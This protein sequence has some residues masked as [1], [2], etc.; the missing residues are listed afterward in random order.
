MADTT[1]TNLALTKPE[2]GASTDT[3]GTKINTDLDTLDAVFKGDGTGTSTGLNV[4]SG[5]TLAVAGTATFTGTATA[6]TQSSGDN[7]TKLATTAY[8]SAITGTSGITGFK[9]RIINPQMQF[10]QRNAGSAVTAGSGYTLDRWNVDRLWTGSTVTIQQS[11]TAPSGFTNSLLAT[12]STGASVA[13]GSYFSIQQF[14]EGYNTADFALGTAS[15]SQFTLSFWVRSSVTGT[16]GVGF[17]NSAF[18]LS[19]WTTYTISAANTWEQKSVTIAAP[20]SGTFGTGNSYGLNTIFSLGCGSTNKAAS[21]NS[22]NAGGKLGA[23][24]QTDLIATTGATFYVTGVQ[25]EKGT[26]ATSFDY[27]P[28]GTELALCQRYFFKITGT[29]RHAIGGNGSIASS[30]P[31]VFLPVTM[32]TTPSLGYSALSDFNSEAIAGAGQAVATAISINTYTT[33]SITLQLT[34]G[35]SSTATG[36][37]L[38]GNGGGASSWT[39]YSAEL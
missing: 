35:G 24:G 27:R 26:Q 14:M 10:D 8:V 5:K 37:Q 25:L 13:A 39:S 19:Y 38:L 33:Q 9:N 31:T 28:Y 7:S 17:R 36:A 23:I 15:A 18:D 32:R 1:T 11:T 16:F 30:F 3:W 34:T 29:G 21:N 4:G 22:W 6:T 12:V 20:T 2:V